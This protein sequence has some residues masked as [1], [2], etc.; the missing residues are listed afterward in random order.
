MNLKK[1]NGFG[2]SNTSMQLC[3]KCFQKH[4]EAHFRSQQG[5]LKKNKKIKD[6][7]TPKV[8]HS[9]AGFEQKEF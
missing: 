9:L 6:S 8:G 2:L 1:N 7:D 3:K 5:M 4:P